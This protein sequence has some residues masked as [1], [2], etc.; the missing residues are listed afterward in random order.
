MLCKRCLEY[1]HTQKRCTSTV[2]RCK[3]CAQ[4]HSIETGNSITI[5]C[6]HFQEQHFTGSPNCTKQIEENE[7]L[8]MQTL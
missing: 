2:I 4:N 6:I 7:I 1:N 5:S 8:A 3:K